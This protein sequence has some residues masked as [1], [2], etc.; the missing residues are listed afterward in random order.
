MDAKTQIAA[1]LAAV[2]LLVAFALA[3]PHREPVAL[4]LAAYAQPRPG[5]ATPAETAQRQN[6]PPPVM[7]GAEAPSPARP[8]ELDDLHARSFAA[9]VQL[10]A[11]A[12]ADWHAKLLGAEAL[13]R[14]RGFAH[15]HSLSTQSFADRMD[16]RAYRALEAGLRERTRQCNDLLRIGADALSAIEQRLTAELAAADSPLVAPALRQA[17]GTALTPEL[18]RQAKARMRQVLDEYGSVALLWLRD[19]LRDLSALEPSKGGRVEWDAD[20]SAEDFDLAT[21]LAQCQADRRCLQEGVDTVERCLASG[22][23]AFDEAGPP[24][25]QLRDTGQRE[26]VAR[27]AQAL[28]QALQQRDWARLGL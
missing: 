17:D 2:C 7:S 11:S 12:D 13:R 27:I 26:R 6:T 14:C 9:L 21:E 19:G 28:A 22:R 1:A 23:C 10:A 5:P 18:L 20:L 4:E 15:Q 16:P 8:R 24:P 3:G 25:A